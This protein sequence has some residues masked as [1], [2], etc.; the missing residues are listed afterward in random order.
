MEID[1]DN[2]LRKENI[3]SKNKSPNLI[4]THGNINQSNNIIAQ[5]NDEGASLE[6]KSENKITPN[7][8][9]KNPI[10][11]VCET[12]LI[13]DVEELK[14]NKEIGKICPILIHDYNYIKEANTFEMIIEFKNYFCAK[15][16]FPH[17]YPFEPPIITFLSG[18]KL[19]NIFDWEGHILLE[20]TKASKWT[21]AFWLS[22]LVKSMELLIAEDSQKNLSPTIQHEDKIKKYGKRKWDDYL[23]LENDL[24]KGDYY[25]INALNKTIKGVK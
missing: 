12:R 25:V 21:P 10:K 14:N 24:F 18:I 7:K 3:P 6:K 5:K 11:S 9:Y 2:N 15:F 16:M 20:Y 17:G 8:P 22:S 13:K 19:S 23:R 4:D 1:I